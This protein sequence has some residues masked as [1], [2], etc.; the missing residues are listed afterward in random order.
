M[1]LFRFFYWFGS[2]TT[3]R[4]IRAQDEKEARAKFAE[5]TNGKQVISVEEVKE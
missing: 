4:Y 3:E 2:V 1:K 5:L